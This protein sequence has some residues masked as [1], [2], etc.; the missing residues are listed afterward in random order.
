MSACPFCGEPTQQTQQVGGNGT[1]HLL[2]CAKCLNLFLVQ[3]EELQSL[4]IE[5]VEDIR[6]IAPRGTVPGEVLADMNRTIEEMPVLPEI[7][8]RIMTMVHD[9]LMT[10]PDLATTINEDAVIATKI[11]KLANS[12]LFGGRGEIASL[13]MAC[14]R[15]GVKEIT[16]TVQAVAFSNLYRTSNETFRDLMQQLWRHAIATAHCATE[17]GK[18][19][20]DPRSGDLFL[21]GL[22]HDIGKVVLLDILSKNAAVASS[23]L[24]EDPRIIVTFLSQ[25]HTLVGLH[26]VNRRDLSDQVAFTTYFHHQPSASAATHW[27]E[28]AHTVAL[29]NALAY[30]IGYGFGLEEGWHAH[31]AAAERSAEFLGLQEGQLTELRESAQGKVEP[32]VDALAM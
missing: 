12:A 15:L 20:K 8:Q 26:T 1:T 14:G 9:P 29:G 4:A 2:G 22:V 28:M 24:R 32:L 30:G 16:H 18:L 3:G 7:P 27:R 23:R 25:Y 21:A 31:E 19:R 10:M 17:I 5:D 6:N 11:L 13:D